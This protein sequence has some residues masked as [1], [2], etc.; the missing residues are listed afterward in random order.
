VTDTS[1]A[2][3]LPPAIDAE[4][5]QAQE[6]WDEQAILNRG[7]QETE[8]TSSAHGT[9]R[10]NGNGNGNEDDGFDGGPVKPAGKHLK[11]DTN[12]STRGV[13]HSGNAEPGSKFDSGRAAWQKVETTNAKSSADAAGDGPK[14]TE[15]VDDDQ[16]KVLN[17]EV[18]AP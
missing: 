12:M 7:R 1:A 18:E 17:A 14:Q 4:A 9:E 3:V 2:T 16:Y 8:S 15:I 11:E 13:N 6:E 10:G 5:R